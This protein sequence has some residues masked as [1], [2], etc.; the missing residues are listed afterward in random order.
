[1]SD[2][3][4]N[5]KMWRERRHLSQSELARAIE[6][7][8]GTIGLY[9]QGRREP[10]FETQEAIADV[11]NVKFNQ[12]HA[13]HPITFEKRDNIDKY[14]H[15]QEELLAIE[16]TYN[17]LSESYKH[18]LYIIAKSLEESYKEEGGRDE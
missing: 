4:K 8:P 3:G 17:R 1:M 14:C 7:S 5:L 10:N 15:E 16:R 6:V 9:E 12:M 13:E 18:Q 11:L 2:Y